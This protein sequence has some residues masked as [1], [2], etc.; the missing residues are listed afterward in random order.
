MT[1]NVNY[2]PSSKGAKASPCEELLLPDIYAC[3]VY[4]SFGV[5][6]ADKSVIRDHIR[7]GCFV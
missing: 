7:M 3:K 1:E 4:I 6:T 2:A 5:F